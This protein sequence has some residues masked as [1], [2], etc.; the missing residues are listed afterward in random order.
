MISPPESEVHLL[1]ISGAWQH[2]LIFNAKDD[3]HEGVAYEILQD[4]GTIAGAH[5]LLTRAVHT[6]IGVLLDVL[7]GVIRTYHHLSLLNNDAV[8]HVLIVPHLSC[9]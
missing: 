5:T 3:G 7:P 2:G 8:R 4:Q 1:V 9:S 6:H